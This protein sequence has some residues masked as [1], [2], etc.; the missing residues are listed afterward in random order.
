MNFLNFLVSQLGMFSILQGKFKQ[1]YE[2]QL[3]Q[4]T[5][6]ILRIFIYRSLYPSTI[7]FHKV[8][9]RLFYSYTFERG[10]D[11]LPK[12]STPVDQ[13]L[14]SKSTHSQLSVAIFI[15]RRIHLG[16]QKSVIYDKKSK[17]YET[18]KHPSGYILARYIMFRCAPRAYSIYM[19]RSYR[20]YM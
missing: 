6:L 7:T 5:S 4:D 20:L 2:C 11:M 1:V 12:R 9:I 15:A 18:H 17:N 8:S 16:A 13:N 19:W 3:L 10:I 14:E